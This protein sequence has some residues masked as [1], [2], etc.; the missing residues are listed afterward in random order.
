M[1][2]RQFIRYLEVNARKKRIKIEMTIT[3]ASLVRALSSLL[4]GITS[5]MINKRASIARRKD[6]AIR[7][8]A[9][10]TSEDVECPLI[11]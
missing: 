11:N 9:S 1:I 4:K 7:R 6:L 2:F 10:T 8:R 3:K 5:S